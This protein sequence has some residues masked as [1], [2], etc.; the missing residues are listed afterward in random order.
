MEVPRAQHGVQSCRQGGDPMPWAPPHRAHQLQ[1]PPKNHRL[2][3]SQ[4]WDLKGPRGSRARSPQCWLAVGGRHSQARP[5]AF[6]A[7][8][9]AAQRGQSRGS[10]REGQ[11]CGG[12]AFAGGG[13]ATGLKTPCMVGSLLEGQE[14][15]TEP[16][17]QLLAND[18]ELETFWNSQRRPGFLEAEGC[19]ELCSEN[20]PLQRGKAWSSGTLQPT[21]SP[22]DSRPPE[23][24]LPPPSPLGIPTA[25]GHCL[26]DSFCGPSWSEGP[27]VPLNSWVVLLPLLVAFSPLI[28]LVSSRF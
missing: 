9:G 22:G 15:P 7:E 16:G 2:P 20:L 18:W 8:M 4:Q 1:S 3:R 25:S 21:P 6:R 17:A 12:R 27:V 5:A 19:N 13:A 23:V 28:F 11:S 10:D 26:P 14:A 24:S